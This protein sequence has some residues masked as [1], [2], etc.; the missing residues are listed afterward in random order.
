MR[1]KIIWITGAGG[2]IGNAMVKTA[3][4]FAGHAEIIGLT[5]GQLDLTDFD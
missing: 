5:R 4:V 1:D 2:L 3:P